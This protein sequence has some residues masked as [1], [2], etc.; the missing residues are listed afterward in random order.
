MVGL[1]H[2]GGPLLDQLAGSA[3]VGRVVAVSRSSDQG[4]ARCNLSRLIAVARGSVPDIEHRAI[5]VAD[6]GELSAVIQK[7]SPDP[8]SYTHLRAHET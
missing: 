1:G 5:D 4:K 8:V 7:V 2:L 6:P 3:L